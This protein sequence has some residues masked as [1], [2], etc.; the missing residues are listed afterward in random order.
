[1]DL[2]VLFNLIL[3]LSF[4]DYELPKVILSYIVGSRSLFPELFSLWKTA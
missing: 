2:L 4:L 3:L 1:M